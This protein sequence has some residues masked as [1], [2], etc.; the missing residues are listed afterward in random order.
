MSD[1]REAWSWGNDRW[2]EGGIN[3]NLQ[4]KRKNGA[5]GGDR[6]KEED[7]GAD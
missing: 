3:R 2:A 5:C 7:R 4:V 1:G 6:R